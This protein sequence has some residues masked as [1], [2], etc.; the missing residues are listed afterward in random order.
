[1]NILSSTVR[2]AESSVRESTDAFKAPLAQQA[3]AHSRL[4]GLVPV[5][6]CRGSSGCLQFQRSGDGCRH[7]EETKAAS[8][9]EQLLTRTRP[10]SSVFR[11]K[12]KGWVKSNAYVLKD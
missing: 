7:S 10:T 5:D 11:G 8:L 4:V 9:P 12:T 2:Q 3:L 1:M 6:G